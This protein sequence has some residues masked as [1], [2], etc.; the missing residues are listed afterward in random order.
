[1]NAEPAVI[2]G[3]RT[4]LILVLLVFF[5]GFFVFP[6]YQE[7]Q[8]PRVFINLDYR[9]FQPGEIVKVTVGGGESVKYVQLRFEDQKLP[10]I[11]KTNSFE[12][13]AFFGLDLS[14]DPGIYP[15]NVTLLY[16][17][18]RQESLREEIFVKP[19]KFPLKKLWVKK[20]YVTPPQEALERIQR[21]SELMSAV[22]GMF[23]P[24][25]LGEGKFILPSEGE[26]VPNF[27]ERR[28][29]NNQPRSPHSGVDISSPLGAPVR[30]SNSGS[31]V[32]ANDL[33]YA[34]KTVVID[35]GLGVFSFYCHFSKIRV[36]I[37]DRVAKGDII[38]EIGATGRV[39]GPHLHWAFRISGSRVDPFSIL[40]L[41]LE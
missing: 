37:G 13:L 24:I 23:T 9:S 30:A 22:Y 25:W 5:L 17:D 8:R 19:K 14:L 6:R 33:Y 12:Y 21:E 10:G 40:D 11:R 3:W 29:F 31:V 38:G 26:V 39:T 16:T 36:Q 20:E 18:G 34:G 7:E 2:T 35:H 4:I 28:I 15:L 27:G 1:V 41:D 32:V